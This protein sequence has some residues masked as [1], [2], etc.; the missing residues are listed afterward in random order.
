MA[1]SMLNWQIP[2]EPP[3]IRRRERTPSRG[4]ARRARLWMETLESRLTPT[5]ST[6]SGASSALWSDNGNWSNAPANTNDLAFP[7]VATN[8]TNTND[9]T[10]ANAFG[11]FSL[12]GSGYVIGGSPISLTGSIDSDQATGVNTVNLPITLTTSPTVTVDHATSSLVLGGVIDGTV[13]LTKTGAGLLDLTQTNTYSGTTTVTAGTLQVDGAQGGSAVTLG[14]GTTLSGVGTVGAVTSAAANITPGDNGTAGA[15]TVNGGLTL[16]ASSTASFT[17]DGPTAGTNYSQLVVSGAI[18]LASANL[19]LT[20]GSGFTPT[21]NQQFTIIHN[22]GNTPITGTFASLPQG[23]VTTVSGQPFRISYVGG[24]GNDVVLTH[25]L[26]SSISLT[27]SPNAPVAGQQVT[28]TATV[29]PTGGTGTP[30]G[31]VQFF[32]GTTSLGTQ[33]LSGGIAILPTSLLTAG[34]N[35]ITAKYLGDANFNGIT[36]APSTVTVSLANTTTTVT[37]V[38]NPSGSGQSVTLTATVVAN[39]PSSYT[40]TGTVTFSD[41]AGTLG[42][43]TLSV[44]GTP[45]ADTATLNVSSLPIGANSITATYGGDSSANT[46]T[47]NA[48]T[49]TVTEGTAGVVLIASKLNPVAYEAITLTANVS[50]LV[51]GGSP[52][53]NVDFFAN[54]QQIGTATITNGSAVLV[55]TQ[56]PI[57]P[58]VISAIYEGD[59]KF[60][61]ATSNPQDVTVGTLQEQLINQ[62]YLD[63][64]DREPTL[65]ELDTWRTEITLGTPMKTVIRDIVYS[66]EAVTNSVVQTFNTLEGV[67]P[68]QAQ[69]VAALSPPNTGYATVNA[70]ILGSQHYYEIN[71][72]TPDSWVT[73]MYTAVTGTEVPTATQTKLVNALKNGA[74]RY[75]I[76]LGV[77]ES[78][79]GREGTVDQ[80]FENILNRDPTDSEAAYFARL[81][82]QGI[83]LRLLTYDLL[84]SEEFIVNF[85][86]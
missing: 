79:A 83:P 45:A 57:G 69:V 68:S 82:G 63:V 54:D 52:T 44:G 70:S 86:G 35:V 59:S 47:S 14:T 76:A 26:A 48:I 37:S 49:Q 73:A 56:L 55:T 8:T 78:K 34:P 77:I 38:P 72:A 85:S 28:L 25:L 32:N 53:G 75:D 7:T 50:D 62:V 40:P 46:S 2:G 51:G 64:L 61:A 16:D 9:L 58:D 81:L 15:M 66:R 29:T 3:T 18:N 22:T 60:S 36:S 10:T 19:N 30:T 13:G 43:G 20:L 84:T 23:A 33:T 1:F 80:L 6:W 65:P 27:T 4:A 41:A 74:S 17:L 71:G 5:T 42:T 24:A 39:V 12:T 31:T 21:G 67:I 11:N